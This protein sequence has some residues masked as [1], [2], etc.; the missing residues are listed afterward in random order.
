MRNLVYL[1]ACSAD[2][3]ISR[4]DG[5]S[6]DFT[7]DGEHVSD[8]LDEYPETIPTHLRD[9]L[10]VTGP[11]RHFDTVLM[12]RRTYEVG[13][14][15][16]F[17]SPYAHLQQFVFS[18]T[19]GRPEN[20]DVTFVASGAVDVVRKL[21]ADGGRDIWLCGGSVL[22]S[23]L[24]SE[25]DQVVLKCNPFLMGRGKPL[26]ASE[27]PRT[28]LKPISCRDYDNGFSLRHYELVRST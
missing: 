16:G 22:A 3:F 24:I 18:T 6:D 15:L 7:L 19:L 28:A 10:G 1:V 21:K 12:G 2:G 17:T 5:S 14:D 4:S 11:N 23:A 20:A 8:L 26:F 13:L 25:I 27:F 9:Q